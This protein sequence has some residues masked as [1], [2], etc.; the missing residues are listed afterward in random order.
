MGR[1]K[2][3]HSDTNNDSDDDSDDAQSS[4]DS[5]KR[6]KYEEPRCV[7]CAVPSVR[8]GEREEF[9]GCDHKACKPCW[10]TIFMRQ[11][12]FG[13]QPK[14]PVSDC[15]CPFGPDVS[16]FL[17]RKNALAVVRTPN[18][19]SVVV[20]VKLLD[21]WSDILHRAQHGASN[22]KLTRKGQ[23][24]SNDEYADI[25]NL[26]INTV[27]GPFICKRKTLDEIH[28]DECRDIDRLE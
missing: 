13:E 23:D 27:D 1:G 24:L 12:R 19:R 15:L 7:V 18:D 10:D 6:I 20:E 28:A 11:L 25:I 26:D 17:P 2:K 9:D 4:K 14:C 8:T 21:K 3:R 5:A 16:S 22:C